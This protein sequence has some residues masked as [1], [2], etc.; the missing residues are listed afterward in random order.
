MYKYLFFD[1]D[2]T[3]CDTEEGIS[4][5]LE[6]TFEHYDTK[7]DRSLY[8]NYIGPPLSETFEAY[9]GKKVAYEAVE[10]FKKN[11]LERKAIFKTKPYDGIA[12][13]IRKCRAAGYGIGVATCKKQEDAETLLR[14]F[15]MDGDVDF[16]SGLKYKERET[17]KDVLQYA[18]ATLGLT[19]DSTVMIGDTFYDVEGAMQCNM[20]CIL[21]LWGF[22][23]Y[24]ALNQSN[25]IYRADKPIDIYQYLLD[26][27]QGKNL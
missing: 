3:L 20:D 24:D 15:G 7:V 21:C 1:F 27:D 11:Y 23:N 16:V 8:R 26:N 13:T 6:L 18:L 4:E 17:K 10:Y 19:A 12:E 5:I 25:I 2:G 9:W 14:Y 22:G